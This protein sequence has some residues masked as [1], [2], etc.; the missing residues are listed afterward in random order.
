MAEDLGRKKQKQRMSKNQ[1]TKNSQ[2][3]D[4]KGLNSQKMNLIRGSSLSMKKQWK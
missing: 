2:I 3:I 4:F 1:Q